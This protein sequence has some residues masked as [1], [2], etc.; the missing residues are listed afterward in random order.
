MKIINTNNSKLELSLYNITGK[1]MLKRNVTGEI[2]NE[3]IN[4]S[5]HSK[6]IYFLK[7]KGNNFTEV[8]KVIYN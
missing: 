1:Q 6:G 4:I 2:I 5:T 8:K 3:E 7:I